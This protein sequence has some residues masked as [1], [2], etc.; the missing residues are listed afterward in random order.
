M[1]T[2]ISREEAF[3]ILDSLKS[4]SLPADIHTVHF[5]N[6][7]LNSLISSFGCGNVMSDPTQ[8]CTMA[9]HVYARYN[10]WTELIDDPSNLQ[11]IND[12]L[13]PFLRTLWD[14]IAAKRHLP[15]APAPMYFN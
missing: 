14:T 8:M 3:A 9:E 5:T 2:K 15:Y 1:T 13:R 10:S 12:G 6:A 4:P 7:E 11:M